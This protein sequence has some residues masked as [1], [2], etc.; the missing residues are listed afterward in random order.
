MPTRKTI[1]DLKL[2]VAGF[3]NRQPNTFVVNGRDNL[4]TAINN[5]KDFIQ[6]AV[7]FE[8][9]RVSVIVPNVN[10][11]R[12]GSLDNALLFE[13]MFG[14]PAPGTFPEPFYGPALG[15]VALPLT[16]PPTFTPFNYGSCKDRCEP[17]CTAAWVMPQPTW[18]SGWNW[19]DEPPPRVDLKK[20][21]IGYLPFIDNTGVAPMTIYSKQSWADRRKRMANEFTTLRANE[22]KAMLA[23]TGFGII[24]D[25]KKFFVDPQ[26]PQVFGGQ[27]T[28]NVYF[29]GIRWLE[30]FN[31][32]TQCQ[33]HQQ[34]LLDYT[35]DVLL[36]RSI[37][38]L[39]FFLK[40][41][42]RVTLSDKQWMLAWNN[43]IQWNATVFGNTTDVSLD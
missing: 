29:D 36:Y 7:D 22:A 17:D 6:R 20:V 38:E 1:L 5:A 4:L 24:M 16:C 30:D 31:N 26:S 35:F 13:Q 11:I 34:F 28:L 10:L 8:Y 3:L 42:E 27:S 2:A 21:L 39:N 40:E 37:M 32:Y 14:S 23:A 25:G 41:D 33:P 12:G 15:Q 18:S 9:A 19:W 43:V